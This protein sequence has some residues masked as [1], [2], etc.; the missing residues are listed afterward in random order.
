M[1]HTF[2][3]SLMIVP[4][5]LVLVFSVLGVT[6]AD[7]SASII[8][9]SG[10]DGGIAVSTNCPGTSCRLRDAIAAAASGG[11]INFDKNYT[12]TLASTL[13]IDKSMTIDG[14]RHKVCPSAATTQ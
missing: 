10:A 14:T 7:A 4:I 13:T 2:K 9:Q 11:T 6:P 8:V 5:L 3:Y 12:I 1:K